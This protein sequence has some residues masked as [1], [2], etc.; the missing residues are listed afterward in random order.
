V[1]SYSDYR[2][3]F[4]E[5]V[6]TAH[7]RGLHVRMVE[8]GTTKDFVGINFE[9]AQA[10]GYSMPDKTIYIDRNLPWSAKYHTLKHEL[11]EISFME[12]GDP[13]WRAHEKAL[14]MER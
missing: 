14:R 6:R 10:F 5:L 7:R 12:S 1:A 3:K 2:E 13:Y 4:H 8:S 11:A 9:A